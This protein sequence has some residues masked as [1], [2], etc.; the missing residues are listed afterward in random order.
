M[1][2]TVMFTLAA[3][4]LAA[5]AAH[6]TPVQPAMSSTS[7]PAPATS[8]AA[9]AAAPPAP[10]APSAGGSAA[11]ATPAGPQQEA[12]GE[13]RR[14]AEALFN[15]YVDLEHAFDPALV[16]L[17]SK[18]ARIQSSV[19]VAGSP[20]RVRK[21]TGATY[22][23]LLGRALKKARETKQDLNYYSSVVYLSAGS[24]VRIKAM[25]Y[26][27]LQKA[28]SPVELL[29]GPDTGGA[30]RIFEERSETHPLPNGPQPVN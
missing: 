24:R 15:R 20:P 4:G 10:S 28:V 27:A 7:A 8:M 30:W 26:A 18:D 3:C 13:A 29:V 16:D 19:I 2:R 22:K 25:R 11:P 17:Y 14:Q 23:E 1:K 9:A 21:W 5:A 12:T 6:A